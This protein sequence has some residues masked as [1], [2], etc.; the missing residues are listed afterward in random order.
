MLV[1]WNR[2]AESH[3]DSRKGRDCPKGG[4]GLF[5][6]LFTRLWIFKINLVYVVFRGEM[7]AQYLR[8]MLLG[9]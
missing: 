1:A 8:I 2:L 9:S 5:L 3:D 6:I 7:D 4:H